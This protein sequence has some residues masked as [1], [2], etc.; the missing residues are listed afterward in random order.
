[1][2]DR[3]RFIGVNHNCYY[4]GMDYYPR[5]MDF[6]QPIQAMHDLAKELSIL[7]NLGIIHCDIK[8]GNIRVDSNG[9]YRLIDFGSCRFTLLIQTLI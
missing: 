2:L 1:M 6:N 4:V 9:I 8:L 3:L 5:E 7:H